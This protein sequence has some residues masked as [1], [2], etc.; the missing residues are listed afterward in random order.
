KVAGF[1]RPQWASR[2]PTHCRQ[3]DLAALS[4]QG[5]QSRMG[6]APAEDSHSRVAQVADC[7]RTLLSIVIGTRCSLRVV[8]RDWIV[9]CHPNFQRADPFEKDVDDRQFAIKP[10]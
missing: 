9:L 5:S 1:R 4:A 6:A 10:S 8:H 7:I 3:P 2:S